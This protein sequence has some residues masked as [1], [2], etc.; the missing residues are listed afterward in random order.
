[1]ANGEDT[2]ETAKLGTPKPFVFPLTMVI[3][4]D[5]S[6]KWLHTPAGSY[7]NPEQ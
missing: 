1:M 3:C 4:A 2:C 5:L 7:G 6:F